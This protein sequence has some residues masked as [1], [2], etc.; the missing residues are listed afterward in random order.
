MPTLEPLIGATITSGI[1]LLFVFAIAHKLRD[2]SHFRE[3]LAGYRVV[4]HAISSAVA[5]TV[6]IAEGAVV[7]G[8]IFPTTRS[9]A[10]GLA[11]AMLLLY[12]G[13]MATNLLRGRVLVDCGCGGFGQRQPLAWWMVR[14][15]A[16]LA[17]VALLAA[18]PMT[19][20]ALTLPDLLVIF[21]ATASAAGLYLAH[22]TL[23]GNRR[24]FA[25]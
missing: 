17:V 12:A 9:F 21:C 23:A 10:A 2:L 11:S 8:C 24:Y 16:L 7:T 13:A 15:N 3:M 4:P 1:A 25:R 5:V 22:A 14:R 6:L 18:W 19:P 20:R